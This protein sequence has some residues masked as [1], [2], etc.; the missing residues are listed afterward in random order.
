M[1]EWSVLVSGCWVFGVG[2]MFWCRGAG[3][4]ASGRSVFG[5]GGL[6]SGW[7]FAVGVECFV[8]GVRGFWY[9]GEAFWCRGGV[10]S[11]SG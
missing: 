3:F 4:L 9:R 11:V 2:L 8:V 5:R 10:F 1:S 7:W 6:E